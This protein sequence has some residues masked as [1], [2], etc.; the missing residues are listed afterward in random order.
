MALSL[1]SLRRAIA[2]CLIVLLASLVA[3]PASGD[4]PRTSAIGSI[5]L[6][7]VLPF[8]TALAAV[9]PGR[10]AFTSC[11]PQ[12]APD[13]ATSRADAAAHSHSA[14]DQLRPPRTHH[15]SACPRTVSLAKIAPL[16]APTGP[17]QSIQKGYSCIGSRR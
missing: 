6:W 14:S 16:T 9:I 8:G 15:F 4:L 3:H 10:M 5:G 1:L 17:R 13:H 12:R 11:A 2:S 7:V